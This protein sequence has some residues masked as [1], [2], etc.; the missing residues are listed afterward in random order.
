MAIVHAGKQTVGIWTMNC[1]IMKMNFPENHPI[2]NMCHYLKVYTNNYR[3]VNLPTVIC[4][5]LERLIMYHVVDILVKYRLV[6]ACQ[7]GLKNSSS[8]LG[9]L[10]YFNR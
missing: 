8:C 4:K 6:D 1:M 5:I 7:Y 10:L 9:P 3:P 2:N